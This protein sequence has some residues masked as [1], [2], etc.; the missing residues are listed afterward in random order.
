MILKEMLFYK[1]DIYSELE[2]I[3]R[4]LAYRNLFLNLKI[5]GGAALIFNGITSV[6][7]QDIDTIE[8][9]SS[10]IKEICD[11]SSLDI[12]TDAMDYIENYVDCEFIEDSCKTFSNIFITYLSLVDTIRTKLKN[13]QDEDKAEKLRYLLEDEF[14]VEMTIEGISEFIKEYGGEPN[15]YDIEE[16]LRY[17]EYI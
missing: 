16:F 12:N 7:T 4:V 15:K 13:Y 17:I 3:N 10:E 9:I 1:E 11:E 8:R 6:E 5:V 14:N 2:K